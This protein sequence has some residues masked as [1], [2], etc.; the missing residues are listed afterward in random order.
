MNRREFVRGAASAA[1]VAKM[2]AKA[3]KRPNFLILYPDQWRY[4]WM[5]GT[6]GVPVLL[7]NITGLARRGVQFKTTVV[8]S[9]LCAP[10]RAC[11]A[12]G[13]EYDECRTPGTRFDFP[14][15]QTTY[16]KLM[17]EA[18]YHVLGCGKID[19]HKATFDW[20]PDGKRCLT[21]WGFT[22]G[23]DNE[24]KFDALWS[25]RLGTPG[26]YVE[27]LKTKDLA[28]VHLDDFNKRF[29][30]GY[31]ATYPT[32]LPD[33]A[34]C[35]N[36]IAGNALGLL[37]S[38]P[39][40]KP[41]HLVVNFTG[42]HDPED[43]TKSMEATARSRDY[44]QPIGAPKQY[45]AET[46]NRIRQ[47]YTAMCE[48]IDRQVG[49]ILS[50]VAK[51]GE[52]DNTIVMFSSDHGEMLGDHD[53]WAKSVPYES[54][55]RVPLII[56]GPCVKRGVQSNALINHIDI[57]ATILD[58]AGVTDL[59]S[60]PRKSFRPVAEGMN[61]KHRN[62]LR[63]GLGAWRMVRDE[64]YKLV[65][66]FD[67]TNGLGGE[68]PNGPNVIPIGPEALR[69]ARKRPPLLFDLRVDPMELTNIAG[70]DPDICTRLSQ[71]LP[72]VVDDLANTVPGK[73][74]KF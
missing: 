46:Y 67:P 13:K 72:A 42:P 23:I 50:E 34:Y 36:W 69:E 18:G 43:I 53:R 73:P 51:R 32:P 26:P 70:T 31:K 29:T 11:L 39:R 65:V 15:D 66:G 57:G 24:G 68:S 40:D 71:Y 55:V 1:A 74:L 37:Q 48:N 61:D 14:L 30:E 16:Y 59:P 5:E 62:V 10:S 17:R 33:D 52:L 20:G 12:S 54:S 35:D 27:F 45:D 64:R 3:K 7:P 9:P 21:E 44:P 6:P 19:L 2:P 4:D 38:A 47:N 25:T 8:A 49:K 58:Y 56:A 22:D 28:Q 63:S 41:W 60:L